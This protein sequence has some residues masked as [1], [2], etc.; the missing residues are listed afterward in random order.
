MSECKTRFLL[1]ILSWILT[2]AMLAGFF[3]SPTPAESC[4]LTLLWL[5]IFKYDP[6]NMEARG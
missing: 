3:E 6:L 4:I 1:A 5:I 2:C